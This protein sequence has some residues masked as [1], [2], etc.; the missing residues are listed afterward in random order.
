[1]PGL[2]ERSNSLAIQPIANIVPNK[3]VV[4][5]QGKPMLIFFKVLNLFSGCLIHPDLY[6]YT[7]SYKTKY[8]AFCMVRERGGVGGRGGGDN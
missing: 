1:M 3:D 6:I 2:D 4:N 5:S 7:Y 8:L